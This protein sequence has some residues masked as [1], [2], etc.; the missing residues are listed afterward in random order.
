MA[1]FCTKCGKQLGEGMVCDCQVNT[2]VQPNMNVRQGTVGTSDI[3]ADVK[4]GFMDC[5]NVFKKVF[6]TPFE[7]IKEFVCDNKFIAGIIMLLVTAI[8]SGLY[9]LAVLKNMYSA[10]ADSF[11][12]NDFSSLLGGILSGESSLMNKPDYLK[13][14]FTSFGMNLVEYALIFALGYLIITK[15][16]KGTASWKQMLTAVALSVTF[17]LVGNVIN[18]VLVFIDGS[19]VANVRSYVSSFAYILSILTLYGA[20][21][22]VSGIDKNKLFIGV[23]SMSVFAT[24]VIDIAKKLFN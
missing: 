17:V 8:T 9:K 14:F 24:V 22:E 2:V 21:K 10:S 19:F 18:S 11:N 16:F 23:A 12:S 20:V 13:E 4:K 3:V 7:A 5:V 15:L 6:T 1:K